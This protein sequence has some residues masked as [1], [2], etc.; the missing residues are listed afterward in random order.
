MAASES[1]LHA[2]WRRSHC[3]LA[4]MRETVKTVKRW[5]WK[6]EMG[7]RVSPPSPAYMSAAHVPSEIIFLAFS[8]VSSSLKFWTFSEL[9]NGRMCEYRGVVP[10]SSVINLFAKKKLSN[11]SYLQFLR[12][13]VLFPLQTITYPIFLNILNLQTRKIYVQSIVWS[14]FVSRGSI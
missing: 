11:K 7:G 8:P 4:R 1:E 13:L 3:C 5:R 12:V 9:N 2:W 14:L 10:S 6:A